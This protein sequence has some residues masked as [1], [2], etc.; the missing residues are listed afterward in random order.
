MTPV[1]EPGIDL[2]A[3]CFLLLLPSSSLHLA[4]ERKMPL[5]LLIPQPVVPSPW[6]LLVALREISGTWDS[7]QRLAWTSCCNFITAYM[8]KINQGWSIK[9]SIQGRKLCLRDL[10]SV[11]GGRA[12]WHKVPSV[13]FRGDSPMEMTHPFSL[14]KQRAGQ[15]QQHL[16]AGWITVLAQFHLQSLIPV[17]GGC[18]WRWGSHRGD[19]PATPGRNPLPSTPSV[20]VFTQAERGK[21]I[22]CVIYQGCLSSLCQG[23]QTAFSLSLS[24]SPCYSSTHSSPRAL[25]RHTF[26]RSV[27]CCWSVLARAGSTLQPNTC[28]AACSHQ[29]P[30]SVQHCHVEQRFLKKA[31]NFLNSFTV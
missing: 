9:G 3:C 18:L 7:L 10:N 15:P 21:G 24:C 4:R 27:P 29:S 14:W 25:P 5:V 22:L 23:K 30:V 2:L 17:I 6:S 1:L 31:T 11:L 13:P 19:T 26:H 8:K 12:G 20:T 16:H 28:V